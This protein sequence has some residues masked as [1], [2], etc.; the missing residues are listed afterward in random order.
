MGHNIV[1]K[2]AGWGLFGWLIAV[3]LLV[4]VVFA[5]SLQII[6]GRVRRAGKAI[7]KLF[8]EPVKLFRDRQVGD[9]PL[10]PV[11]V[12]RQA[13]RSRGREEEDVRNIDIESGID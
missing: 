8:T 6:I 3:F 1:P 2:D 5:L 11:K 10:S 7:D 4:T 12:L 9:I 13:L